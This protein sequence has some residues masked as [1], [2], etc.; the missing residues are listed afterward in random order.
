EVL[1]AMGVKGINPREMAS[2]R[3]VAFAG[4]TQYSFSPSRAHLAH[5][6]RVLEN[7]DLLALT[8][9]DLFWDRVIAIVPAGEEDG[10]DLTVPATA[11][12][13]ADGVVSHNSG[14]L[15]QD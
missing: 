12:W 14:A 2:L 6:A 5:Y 13:L 9:S 1:A 11:S 3:G 4:K 15:E 7:A 10:Y 8:D